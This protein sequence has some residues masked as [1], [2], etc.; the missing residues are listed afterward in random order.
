LILGV[1]E[2]LVAGYVGLQYRDAVGFTTLILMLMWRPHGLFS[3]QS[4]F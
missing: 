1:A 3:T 4:R 2:S